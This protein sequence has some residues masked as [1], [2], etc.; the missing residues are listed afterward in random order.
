MY[1]PFISDIGR[2]VSKH[3]YNMSMGK[4]RLKDILILTVLSVQSEGSL[5]NGLH[6]R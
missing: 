1:K 6:T 3:V 5:Q 2:P 4:V